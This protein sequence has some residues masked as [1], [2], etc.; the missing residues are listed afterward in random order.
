MITLNFLN[1]SVDH[2]K[3]P[4]IF[5]WSH[6]LIPRFSLGINP[7]LPNRKIREKMERP[8][9][10]VS[11]FH[12]VFIFLMETLWWQ[13]FL[14]LFLSFTSLNIMWYCSKT[15]S[16]CH[17]LLM[18]LPPEGTVWHFYSLGDSSNVEAT[19][20]KPTKNEVWLQ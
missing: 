2:T 19:K 6:T 10:N 3:F 12:S 7:S 14:S 11:L 18:M 15:R 20:Y 1:Y 13:M 8:P 4:Q 17:T 16:S 9:N 5:S